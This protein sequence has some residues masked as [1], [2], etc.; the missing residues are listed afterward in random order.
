MTDRRETA[1]EFWD[2]RY[3][4]G[5]T[6]WDFGGVPAN[7]RGYLA[8]RKPFGRVLVPGCGS[9]YDVQALAEAG[10]E[11]VGIDLSETAVQRANQTATHSRATIARGDVF[12]HPFPENAFDAIYERTFLCALPPEDRE[13]YRDRVRFLLKPGGLL[14]GYFLY[15]EESD[16]PPY[17]MAA[18][19]EIALLGP[20]FDRLES[21]F[22]QD[23]L[24]V[25]AGMERWEIWRRTDHR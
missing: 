23:P 12:T 2:E 18:G 6:P 7:L 13:R 22:S 24:P 20:W 1:P 5:H 15:G 21:Y 4:A 25:F 10:N 16:P 3:R 8:E 14:F 11:V 9:G 17:P 19:E